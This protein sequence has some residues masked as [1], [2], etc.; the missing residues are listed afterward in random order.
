MSA[1]WVNATAIYTGT[2]AV[3]DWPDGAVFEVLLPHAV[4]FNPSAVDSLEV[5]S[6]PYTNIA[7]TT[8]GLDNPLG[9]YNY[10][11]RFK[12]DTL[13]FPVTLL[14]VDG[15]PAPDIICI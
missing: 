2:S 14:N 9:V 3:F 7:T 11:G 10:G 12:M 4:G 15:T 6:T 13:V 5:Q 8:A 1:C